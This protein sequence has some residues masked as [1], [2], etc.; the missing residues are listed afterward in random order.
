MY[1]KKNLHTK[2]F[3]DKEILAKEKISTY[4][5]FDLIKKKMYQKKNLLTKHFVTKEISEEKNK[6]KIFVYLF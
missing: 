5:K 4:R 1:K 3:V 2:L 6:K